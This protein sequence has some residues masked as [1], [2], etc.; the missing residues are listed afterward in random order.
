MRRGHE[1]RGRFLNVSMKTGGISPT[2]FRVLRHYPSA[3]LPVPQRLRV[4]IPVL[5]ISLGCFE[6]KWL[7]ENGSCS[8]PEE[9]D[10]TER[11]LNKMRFVFEHDLCC[12]QQVVTEEEQPKS[13]SDRRERLEKFGVVGDLALQTI[14]DFV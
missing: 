1:E 7:I 12:I 6:D 9:F 4:R 13:I 8:T 5:E 14:I 2:C 3:T 10:P 11:C